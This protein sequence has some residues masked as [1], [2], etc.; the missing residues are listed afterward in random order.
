MGASGGSQGGGDSGGA[1][2][3]GKIMMH[4]QFTLTVVAVII[5]VSSDKVNKY[6]YTDRVSRIQI[7]FS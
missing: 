6:V 7:L 1:A 4:S 5:A 3:K 2:G